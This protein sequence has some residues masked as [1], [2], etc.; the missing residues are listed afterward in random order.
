MSLRTWKAFACLI[1]TLSLLGINVFAFGDYYPT[2]YQWSFNN[3][4]YL[5][6]NPPINFT[7]S[8]NLGVPYDHS[9]VGYWNLNEGSGSVAADSSGNG[10]NGTLVNSPTWVAG[11]YGTGLSFSGNG[12]YVNIP[13]SN[14]LNLTKELTVA[15]WAKFVSGN[16]IAVE[17]DSSYLLYWDGVS[18]VY[19]RAYP[20]PILGASGFHAD[21][22]WHQIVYTYAPNSQQVLYIDGIP[23]KSGATGNVTISV[24]SNALR[25]GYIYGSSR[26]ATIDDVRIYNRALSAS[27]VAVLYEQP[28][29][30]Y[31]SNYYN[32]QDPVTNNSVLIHIDNPN[33]DSNNIALVT[34]RDFFADDRLVF[35]ANNSATINVW[36]NLGQPVFT[37]GVWNSNNFTTNL[38]LEASSTAELNWNT[39]YNITTFTDAYS[40]VSPSNVTVPYLGSKTFNFN[41]TQGYS[42]SVTVDGAVQGQIS[43]YTFT[44]VIA[45]HT[46]NI[47][48]NQLTYRIIA[49][50]DAHSIITPGNVSVNYGGSQQFNMTANSGYYISLVYID[51]VD[52]GNLTTYNFANVQD[53]HTISVT[54]ATLAPTNTPTPTTS[55]TPSP[56]SN[57]P[58]LTASPTP[59]Q[60][61]QP[62]ASPFPIETV[63]IAA[64]VIAMLIAVFV[65][66]FQKGYVT[67]EIVNEENPKEETSKEEK[68]KPSPYD[69][70]SLFY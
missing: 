26:P 40:F 42:F 35:Q 41:A 38:T 13:N 54:S 45:S 67:I 68:P 14:S 62:T 37:T 69:G 49:S 34:C 61:L 4:S 33:G 1:A 2:S 43:N 21:N 39:Y 23:V 8:P 52:E 11:K 51:G 7:G 24:N 5:D 9:L 50:A 29:P 31:L 19:G 60:I 56:P 15:F 32:Y 48:S 20:N 65:F 30:V 27:E 28:D 3:Y 17:K 47:V 18:Y 53:N 63:V 58:N 36:T 16:T 59:S 46:V 10:N 64:V 22:N 12:D 44:N 6:F 70:E 25:V 66:A 55:L 57:T